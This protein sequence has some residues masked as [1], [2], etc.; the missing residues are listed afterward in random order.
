MPAM[1]FRDRACG[2]VEGRA[3]VSAVAANLWAVRH[4]QTE[5][6]LAGRH[7]GRTDVPL[8]PAG[9]A[10]AEALGAVLARAVPEPALVLT[11]PLSRAAETCRLAG[12]G[13]HAEPTED[14]VEWDYGDY[15]GLTTA[16]VR[17]THPGWTLWADGVPGGES[18][19][20]V[21]RR[22]DAV[23][24]R[25]RAEG[26]DVVCFA[27]GHFLRVLAARWV[28]LPPAAGRLLALWPGA[29]SALGWEREVPV[30]VRWN[31]PA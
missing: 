21:G 15:E 17:E 23:V 31:E 7:T 24:R 25:V 8:A 13:D 2:E 4:G 6:S 16:Q 5:W 30:V 11:S 14:L 29:L 10:Q 28:G 22:A 1:T 3:V 20:D 18:A 9:I 12:F 19:A 26:G 27:H